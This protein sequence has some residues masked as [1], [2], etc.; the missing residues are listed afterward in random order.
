VYKQKIL[1]SDGGDSYQL[2]PHIVSHM[3]HDWY[4][5][6]SRRIDDVNVMEAAHKP[7]KN[8]YKGCS[9]RLSTVS[10]EIYNK[11]QEIRV[12]RR[13]FDVYCESVEV[14]ES[15]NKTVNPR[16]VCYHTLEDP[17]V[18][19]SCSGYAND[20]QELKYN[21]DTKKISLLVDG[22]VLKYLSGH[23]NLEDIRLIIRAQ[24]EL[25]I[26]W[27]NYIHNREGI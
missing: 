26:F 3:F 17:N 18:T 1:N 23:I 15:R 14:I 20:F 27:D 19:F 4:R 16:C 5:F 21:I 2:K 24:P 8:L 22:E 25:Y 7:V 13:A 9:R 12:L 11:S 6:S 10:A